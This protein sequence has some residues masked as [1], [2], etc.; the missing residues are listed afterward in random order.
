MPLPDSQMAV[1]SC[2]E[3]TQERKVAA[4]LPALLQGKGCSPEDRW[5][6]RSPQPKLHT[7]TAQGR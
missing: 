1:I 6:L 5:H 2:G 4:K 7:L 3:H